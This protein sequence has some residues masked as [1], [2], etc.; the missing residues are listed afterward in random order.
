MSRKPDLR[1]MASISLDADG[2]FDEV[3]VLGGLHSVG[4]LNANIVDIKGSI[5]IQGSLWANSINVMGG[6]TIGADMIA[7]Y[8]INIQGGVKTGGNLKG[9]RIEVS[10]GIKSREAIVG[11]N[12]DV[13]GGVSAVNDIKI[14]G[15]I[16]VLGGISSHGS[17]SSQSL[18]SIGGITADKNVKVNGLVNARGKIEIGG[19]VNCDEFIFYISSP[20]II[21]G[22]LQAN[23]IRIMRDENAKVEAF[24]RVKEI[25]SPYRLDIDYV[26]TERV[27]CPKA[28]TGEN[29]RIGESIEKNYNPNA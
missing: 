18:S 24:L 14:E 29:C 7:E 3:Y 23:K 10:G 8:D 19:D 22:K 28:R 21:H 5:D 27:I 4:S 26:I 20:S 25:V 16:E 13:K 11:T 17:I 2:D 15:P 9:K 1:A 12:L 6:C